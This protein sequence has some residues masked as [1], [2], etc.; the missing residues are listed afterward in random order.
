MSKKKEEEFYVGDHVIERNIVKTYPCFMLDERLPEEASCIGNQLECGVSVRQSISFTV[1]EHMSHIEIVIYKPQTQLAFEDRY[2]YAAI[3]LNAQ[4]VRTC[5]LKHLN[6]EVR[7]QFLPDVV[8]KAGDIFYLLDLQINPTYIAASRVYTA[9]DPED[10]FARVRAVITELDEWGVIIRGSKE[11]ETDFY[12]LFEALEVE[13]EEK[14]F[15]KWF[16]NCQNRYRIQVNANL[17]KSQRPTYTMPRR[18]NF[19]NWSDY[20]CTMGF[21]MMQEAE[22]QEDQYEMLKQDEFEVVLLSMPFLT[23][24]TSQSRY[25]CLIYLT[26]GS[27][28][29]LNNRDVLLI[30]FDVER[31][32]REE[33][34]HAVVTEP[35]SFVPL[36]TVT[37]IITRPW[38]RDLQQ[39]TT[40]RQ[41]LKVIP[42]DC[43]GDADTTRKVLQESEKMGVK[44]QVVTSNK[45]YRRNVKALEEINTGR[46]QVDEELFVGNRYDKL[47]RKDIYQTVRDAYPDPQNMMQLNETQREVVC[48]AQVAPAGLVIVNGPPGTGKTYLAIQMCIPFLLYADRTLPIILCSHNNQAV[49]KLAQDITDC[50]AQLRSKYSDVKEHMVIRYHSQMAEGDIVVLDAK[51]ARPIPADARPAIFKELTD[52]EEATLRE[53]EN[54]AVM[55]DHYRRHTTEKYKGVRDRRVTML[56]ESL[57]YRMLQVAG[58]FESSFT[59]P[60]KFGAFL[61]FMRQYRNNEEWGTNEKMA[62]R[63]AQKELREY[64]ISKASVICCSL[65]NTA[66]PPL[67]QHCQPELIVVD[68]AARAPEPDIW[69]IWAN[70]PKTAARILIGDPKQL[71]PRVHSRREVN[72]FADQ[73]NVAF[74]S[75]LEHGGFP[76]HT[77]LEQRRAVSTIHHIYNVVFYEGCLQNGPGT[78]T[79]ERPLS[80]IVRKFNKKMYN[81]DQPAVF[82]DV[83]RSKA[84]QYQVGGSWYNIA[85]C[86]ATANLVAKLLMLPEIQPEHITIL[87]PYQAQYRMY[88][89]AMDKINKQLTNIAVDKVTV[90]KVDSYQGKENH[91]VILDLVVTVN[92]GFL[93]DMARLVVGISRARDGW[94][95]IANKGAI[96][97]FKKREGR[98]LKRVLK[99]VM[100]YRYTIKKEEE[101]SQYLTHEDVELAGVED[102]KEEEDTPKYE[103]EGDEDGLY[104]GDD[105]HYDAGKPDQVGPQDLIAANLEAIR[106]T[107]GLDEYQPPVKIEDN[108]SE[109]QQEA[110]PYW[111]PPTNPFPLM[112]S[113]AE[114]AG[115]TDPATAIPPT[116]FYPP[117]F[118]VPEVFHDFLRQQMQYPFRHV[119]G[120][121]QIPAGYYPL[122]NPFGYGVMPTTTYPA[123]AATP[124]PVATVAQVPAVFPENLSTA[125]QIPQSL[126]H[127]VTQPSAGPEN[128]EQTVEAAFEDITKKHADA[129]PQATQTTSDPDSGIVPA[130]VTREDATTEVSSSRKVKSTQQ[131]KPPTTKKNI[132]PTLFIDD[133]ER[134]RRKKEDPAE[135]KQRE[136]REK[137]WY[138][139]AAADPAGG[140]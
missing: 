119:P 15:L 3:Q 41:E 121:G 129:K 24:E 6:K 99:V 89:M 65:A 110:R 135:R 21:G 103:D 52:V 130:D 120:L 47:D 64:T 7:R 79:S 12:D 10:P 40:P 23:Q 134:G 66:D 85:Q 106:E 8:P 29:R 9:L 4:A 56:E 19:F 39:W 132:G 124:G 51:R 83:A 111:Q 76:T 50:I 107:S 36:N 97:N 22:T 44:I 71:H 93:A 60:G 108:T 1:N 53:V 26:E 30:N 95:L 96:D 61:E 113:Q 78:R 70:F 131:G 31:D 80:G 98:H 18:P 117:W 55:Y 34:W 38:D 100:D 136:K 115:A 75:R 86:K 46:A 54:A 27:D 42:F 67:F 82:L 43:L 104:E 122:M 84:E 59:V 25:Y 32:D 5:T 94:Y 35:L 101:D 20:L 105:E 13:R 125:T 11:T 116:A 14:P 2:T 45:V 102:I 63:E 114:A 68:E 74:M 17:E 58:Y 128:F 33:D 133:V 118:P 69:T 127:N 28:I 57:G 140:W 48:D 123:P 88:L 37:A 73:L 126:P 16:S 137:E 62:F 92:P 139:G 109:P 87:T 49:D 91:I 81:I 112:T 72:G 77:L 90:A 138:G